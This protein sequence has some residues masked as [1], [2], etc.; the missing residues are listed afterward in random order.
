VDMS[1]PESLWELYPKDVHVEDKKI[2]DPFMGGGTSLVEAS[3]F[4]AEVIG[5][6]LN[7]VAWFVTKKELEAGQ[8]DVEELEEAFE[9]VKEDVAD[10]ITQYY[11]TPCPNGD[12]Q[13]DV[14][15]NFWVKELD[16][17]SCSSTIPLFK[18][19]RVGNSRYGNKGKYNVLCPDCEEINLINDWQSEV[20]CESCGKIFN[21]SEGNTGRGKY[22]C[23]H[24]GLKYPIID[25]IQEQGGFRVRQYALEYYCKNCCEDGQSKERYKGYKSAGAA[26][27]ELFKQAEE[28][29]NQ[30]DELRDYVP[31]H[32]IPLGIKTDSS[33]F[34]GNISGGHSLLR[35]GYTDW[36]DMYNP[37][38]LLCLSKLLRSIDSIE[39]QNA[40]EFLLLAF[41]DSLRTNSMMAAYE[42]PTNK[43]DHIFRDNNF[44]PP[45][46]PAE[47]NVWGT[48]DGRGTFTSMWDMIK[49][50]VEYASAPTERFVNDGETQETP[51]FDMGVGANA[52]VQL[53]DV[54]NLD[55]KN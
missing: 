54:R 17:T 14:M 52:G 46:Y 21:P 53:G 33:Q 4:G 7:P 18:D 2:L 22:T 34:E 27:V 13:A 16:C 47:N 50:G 45:L 44:N 30:S 49:N 38:Q 40:K 24:C 26:D 29:W 23:P 43:I 3:R 41:S 19:Y 36:T 55:Q 25:A 37:R 8:T 48:V 15:Y 31:N 20:G 28:E 42:T 12:H 51:E 32:E 5:N 9:Q 35:Q 1:D 6:D 39:D 11:K 10:E